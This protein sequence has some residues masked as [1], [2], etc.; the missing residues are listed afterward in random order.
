SYF[1]RN[2]NRWPPCMSQRTKKDGDPSLHQ[3][4]L[5]DHQMLKIP[6]IFGDDICA[7]FRQHDG[8]RM[9]E[10]ADA[11]NVYAGLHAEYH[12][13]LEH[14]IVVEPERRFLMLADADAMPCA[15]R[16]VFSESRLTYDGKRRFVDFR[17]SDAGFDE[18][19]RCDMSP[20]HDFKHPALAFCRLPHEKGP[21]A[22]RPVA[23]Q[24]HLAAVDDHVARFQ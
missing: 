5:F 17:R 16:D 7:V 9:P 2:E 12:A 4:C 1:I 10:P 11:R 14:E 15:V 23:V 24:A 21:F 6:R 18:I 3:K 20:E 8:I 19:K 13:G 22:F